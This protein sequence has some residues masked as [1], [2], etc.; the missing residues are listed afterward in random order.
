MKNQISPRATMI[1]EASGNLK[2]VVTV[3]VIAD[4]AVAAVVVAG[5]TTC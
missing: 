2:N 5:T 4:T 3:D 1:Q